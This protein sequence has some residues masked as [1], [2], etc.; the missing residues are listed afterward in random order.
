MIQLYKKRE[1]FLKLQS[2]SRTER[3]VE[4]LHKN[5]NMITECCFAINAT[6]MYIAHFRLLKLCGGFI[7]SPVSAVVR[8]NFLIFSI[9]LFDFVAMFSVFPANVEHILVTAPCAPAIE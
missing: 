9:S 6:K 5:L 7:S 2:T 4:V 3:K 8:S 1:I